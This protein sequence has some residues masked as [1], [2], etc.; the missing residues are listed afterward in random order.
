MLH[1]SEK[2]C[3]ERHWNLHLWRYSKSLGVKALS[4]L[5]ELLDLPWFEQEVALR[6]LPG[7]PS[8]LD[9]YILSHT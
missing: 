5:T 4:K 7:V 1:L 2:S 8:N 9:K 3:S 6:C